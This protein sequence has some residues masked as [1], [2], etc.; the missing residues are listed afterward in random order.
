MFGIAS[1][2]VTGS[3]AEAGGDTTS[4]LVDTTSHKCE[5]RRHIA[6]VLYRR[7]DFQAHR[8]V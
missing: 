6:L 8:V 1:I 5:I 3:R 2:N 4:G 7:H